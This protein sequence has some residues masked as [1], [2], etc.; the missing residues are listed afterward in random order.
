M[1]NLKTTGEK[2]QHLSP[3]LLKNELMSRRHIRTLQLQS[4]GHV[5]RFQSLYINLCLCFIVGMLRTMHDRVFLR[6]YSA[7]PLDVLGEADAEV[8]YKGQPLKFILIVVK[9]MDQ[10]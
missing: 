7:E 1:V 8:Q 3:L 10:V 2:K 5:M 6:T 4:M 9:G